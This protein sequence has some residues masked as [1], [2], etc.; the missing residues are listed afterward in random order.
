MLPEADSKDV[1]REL[2]IT[3]HTIRNRAGM[4]VSLLNYG[5]TITEIIVP[6]KDGNFENVVLGFSTLKEFLGKN[7]PY[8]GALMGRYANRIGQATFVLDGIGYKLPDNNNGNTLHGGNKGFDKVFWTVEHIS[9]SSVRLIYRSPDGEEGFP[10]NL[11]VEV[12]LTV[13][14]EN[15]LTLEYTATTDQATPVNLTSH[16]YF[17]LSAGKDATILDHVLQINAGQITEVN[18][19]S[20]PT[21]KFL[22]VLET[23]FD[24]R[25]PKRVGA[26]IGDATPGYDHNFVLSIRHKP[27]SIPAAE[28]YDPL[29]G[30]VMRLYTTEP[31]L[32]FYSGNF[33]DGTITGP[34]GQ[35]YIKHAGLCLEPQHF[36]D[37]PNHQHFPNTILRPGETYKQISR[38]EFLVR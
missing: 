35:L 26:D 1:G 33:L 37:S 36:P 22:D 8:F 17:N 21:G 14:V 32:Q 31:G 12:L 6:D 15:T 27:L 28:L 34:N 24:F 38:L 7:N 13:S 10:G 19:K 16:P 20:I 4:R 3:Q 9:D 18:S 25:T 11:Q 2:P 23:P 30:R 29:S 5:G